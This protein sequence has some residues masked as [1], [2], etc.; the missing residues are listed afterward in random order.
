MREK[1]IEADALTGGDCGEAWQL[2]KRQALANTATRHRA[3]EQD[4]E[5]SELTLKEVRRRCE[6]VVVI[7]R[8]E[9]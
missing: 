7:Q 9:A 4:A 2:E 6:V 8:P 5:V 1:K 3:S